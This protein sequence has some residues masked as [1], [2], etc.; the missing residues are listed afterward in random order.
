MTS[1]L[2]VKDVKERLK[3]MEDWQVVHVIT[4]NHL[5]SHIFDICSEGKY[6]ESCFFE[7]KMN[8]GG[9]E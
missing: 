5:L 4:C 2:T 8:E 7:P 3:K 1:P 9:N 6:V